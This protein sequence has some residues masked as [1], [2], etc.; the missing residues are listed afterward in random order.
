MTRVVI[1]EDDPL[2][3]EMLNDILIDKFPTVE[4]VGN[5]STATDAEILINSA[6][7]DLLFLDVELPGKSGFDLLNDLD[8]NRPEIIVVSSYDKYALDAFKVSA[9]DFLLKPYG[10]TQLRN[11]LMKFEL[12]RDANQM[13]VKISELFSDFALR[14]CPNK[15]ISIPTISGMDFIDVNRIIRL[16]AAVNYTHFYLDDGKKICVSRTL[17]E[18][19]TML[20]RFGFCRVHQSHIVNLRYVKS[21]SK[22]NGGVVV[23]DNLSEIDV[24]KSY[25]EHFLRSMTSI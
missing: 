21:Y 11:A 25:K 24:S 8:G 20:Y 16:Q 14:F 5:C 4:I 23:L 15:R 10:E 6:R 7:P 19:E 2:S 18:F 3:L 13:E 1:V 9:I 17:K 12:K 22:G